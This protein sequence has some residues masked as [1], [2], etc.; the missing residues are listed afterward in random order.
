MK[1]FFIFLLTNF[2]K[3]LSLLADKAAVVF[4][5]MR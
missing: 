4:K 5:I 3:F 1:Y 2:D